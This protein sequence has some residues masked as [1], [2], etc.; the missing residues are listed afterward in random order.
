MNKQKA[1]TAAVSALLTTIGLVGSLG[2]LAS[3]MR[4]NMELPLLVAGC[5][6]IGLAFSFFWDTRLWFVPLCAAALWLWLQG[7]GVLKSLEGMLYSISDLYDRGYGWGIVQWSDRNTLSL[8]ATLALL[9]IGLPIGALVSLQITKG[10]QIWPGVGLLLLPLV[11][12]LL[13][14]DTVPTEEY[15]GL[16]LFAAVLLLLTDSVRRRDHKQANRLTMTLFL[17]LTL[18]LALLFVFCPRDT[19]AG[20]EGAQKIEDFIVGL[21]E[22]TE[23]PETAIPIY[24]DQSKTVALAD[25]GRRKKDTTRI[26]TVEAQETGTIYLRGCAYDIYDGTTWTSTPGWNG[27]NLCYTAKGQTTK[28]LKIKT[29]LPHSVLYFTYCPTLDQKVLG[30][31]LRNDQGLTEYTVSYLDPVAYAD[32]WDERED[33]VGGQELTEY[34]ELPYDTR[35]QALQ[36]LNN[37]VGYPTDTNNTGQIWRNARYIADWVSLRAKYDLNTDPM[38][39]GETDFAIWFLTKAKTGYCTHYASATVVLLRA[40]GIPAQYVTGYLVEA[41]A[42]QPVTVTA[43]NAHAWVEVFINGVGWVVLE[44]TP[45][46]GGTESPVVQPTAPSQPPATT[47]SGE[48]TAEPT[49]NVYPDTTPQESVSIHISTSPH[50]V[51]GTSPGVS[52]QPEQ[53]PLVILWLLLVPPVVALQWRLRVWIDEFPLRRGETNRQALRYWK[54]LE[55]TC[56]LGRLETPEDCYWLAQKARFSQHTLTS[57]ELHRLQKALAEVRQSLRKHSFLRQLAYT[58]IF[59]LY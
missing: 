5:A 46:A 50:Q 7:N 43:E 40:A 29:Q 14:K 53:F 12:C 27:W 59:A 36:I 45:S 4:L 9:A 22:K 8:D 49:I 13:L 31:R 15:L 56:R 44:P 3:G 58:L 11:S 35:R 41:K 48:T 20:Q 19:Y 38:P 33:M 25:V 54:L 2:C 26:M 55:R 23:L 10:W 52:Q 1:K 6:L 47:P 51:P 39:K 57:E 16:I 21:F 42:G 18:G 17:P 24:G 30:G 34:L 28:T 32:D 37:R